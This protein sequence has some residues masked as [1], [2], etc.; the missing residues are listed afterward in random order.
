MLP[1][2]LA[3]SHDD[4]NV[5][6]S[7]SDSDPL[8]LSNLQLAPDWVKESSTP[9]N[10]DKFEGK[11]G[12]RRPRGPK[13]KRGRPPKG[14]GRGPRDRRD[15]RGGGKPG[16]G[17][18]GRR[19]DFKSGDRP[20]RG[21]GKGGKGGPRGRREHRPPRLEGLRLRILPHEHGVEY[22]AHQIKMTG[23]AYSIF[24]LAGLVISANDRYHIR[25][26]KDGSPVSE[27][28]TLF[29]CKPDESLWL[30]R[31]DA[32]RHA[33]GLGEELSAYYKVE[34]VEGEPPKGNFTVIA[35]CGISG[36][37][38]GPPNHHDYQAAINRLHQRRFSNM[39]IDAYKNRIKMERDEE[40]IDKWKE[41]VSVQTHYTDLQPPE[42]TEPAVLKSQS[43]LERHFAEQHADDVIVEISEAIIPGDIPGKKLDQR[44]FSLLRSEIDRQKRFPMDLVQTLC[45]QLEAHGLKF[46]KR[47]KKATFVTRSRPRPINENTTLSDNVRRIVDYIRDHPGIDLN[48]LAEA[49]CGPK[50]IKI[51]KK[52]A[53]TA[54]APEEDKEK[55]E[56]SPQP[57]TPE[58]SETKDS[59]TVPPEEK[60]P[61]PKAESKEDETANISTEE[62]AILQDLRWLVREGFV[63]EYNTGG[64]LHLAP[65]QPRKRRRKK[66]AVKRPAPEKTGP[67]SPK[68]EK[69]PA[70]PAEPE[71]PAPPDPEPP[72][73][74]ESSPP[75]PEP[76]AA[77]ES[78]PPE[79]EPPAENASPPSEP[80]PP[81]AN[82]SPPPEPESAPAVE[83]DRE[84]S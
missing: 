28:L 29:Q 8:D 79:P 13:G 9:Q 65:K 26:E 71:P 84:E 83:A 36:E 57:E 7:M 60:K 2:L 56:T 22:L 69:A 30:S 75:E 52:P 42:G 33:V 4:P 62:I 64:E 31:D 24:D 76:P 38:L 53:P 82:E 68:S 44:I 40:T 43:E 21:K 49:L 77:N 66:K 37:I 20:Y 5:H 12:E 54:K 32:L 18:G 55:A 15:D 14:K 78:P 51:E 47:D 23:R 35:V 1:A 6:T 61:E 67:S 63:I 50:V 80:E 41:K 34:R 58:A 16:G 45:R 39:S 10:Y 74:N 72:A 70:P 46:F 27:S 11:D 73:E 17:G 81:A 59:E 3:L 48:Q 19:R 25:F